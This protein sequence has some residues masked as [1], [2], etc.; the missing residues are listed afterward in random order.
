MNNNKRLYRLFCFSGHADLT[1]KTCSLS[2]GRHMVVPYGIF[3]S[4]S[5]SDSWLVVALISFGKCIWGQ[6]P[7]LFRFLGVSLMANVMFHPS[8]AHSNYLTPKWMYI[9][10]NTFRERKPIVFT[11]GNCSKLPFAVC[12]KTGPKSY[13][14]SENNTCQNYLE[15]ARALPSLQLT[16]LS[17]WK[18]IVGRLLSFRQGLLSVA[19]LSIS[20]RVVHH[21]LF[22][23]SGAF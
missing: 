12:K 4:F 6:F 11:A 16:W 3:P 8:K 14:I 9:D 5:T 22:G 21:G 7:F 18:L 2:F 19:M 15:L 17:S 20:G 23:E 13:R 10:L 1:I